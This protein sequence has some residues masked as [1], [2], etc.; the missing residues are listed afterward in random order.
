MN[1]STDV[2]S[3]GPAAPHSRDA[4]SR[5]G[6]LEP[7]RSRLVRIACAVVGTIALAFGI[8]GVFLPLLPTTPFLLLAGACYARA[9]THLYG[10]LLGQ[11]AL[12]PIITNWRRS[13]AL[14]PG[15]RS[16]AVVVVVLSFVVSIAFVELAPLRAGLAAL[17]IVLTVFL[18]RLPVAP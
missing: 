17:G 13:R 16:R 11:P 2:S 12:G 5:D 6:T 14:P 9:S 8:V 7:A 4:A 3:P 10:W 15:V 1:S 18:L